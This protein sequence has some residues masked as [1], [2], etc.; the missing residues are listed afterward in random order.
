MAR[1]TIRLGLAL[2]LLAPLP[3][4]A[5]DGDCVVLLHGLGRSDASLLVMEEALGAG[6]RV[7]NLGYPSTE[8]TV[9]ELL[10]TVTGAVEACGRD[11]VNFVTHSMGGILARGWLALNRP[12]NIG[13][14]VMLAPPNSGVGGRRRPG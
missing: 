4:R 5:Q 10:G 1:W 11:R 3:G 8:M 2:A 9:G 12:A 7:V 14:V 6:M 13:R